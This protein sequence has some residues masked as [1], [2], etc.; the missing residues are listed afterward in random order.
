M[1][2]RRDKNK[3]SF[4]SRLWVF[5]AVI[6]LFSVSFSYM[7]SMYWLFDLF[8]H[9]VVQYVLIAALLTI[10]LLFAKRKM[11]AL[12][13]L[14][15]C[16]SQAYK[17]VP[18]FDINEEVTEDYDEVKVLQYNVNRNNVN[19]D[20]MTRWIVSKTEDVDIVVL[21]EVNERWQDAI[22]RIKWAYPYHISKD[23]RGGRNMAVFSRLYV[24]EIEIK[25]LKDESP[26]IVLRGE[27]TGYE[28]P[29]VLYGTHPPPPIFPSFAQTNQDVLESIGEH[30]VKEKIDHRLVVGDFNSTRFSPHFR[31]MAESSNMK[32]GDI[33]LGIGAYKPSW[34]SFLPNLMGITIDN[35]LVS[36]NIVVQKRE[37][38]PAMGSDHYPVITT[39]K[40][41]VPKENNG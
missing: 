23:M 35:I 20:E 12:I 14:V 4:I 18:Y 7:A 15:I 41:V 2:R 26:V 11:W 28:V 30:V 10:L 16:A 1:R 34:P 21:L 24:D 27:T 25:Y 6:L 31:K 36:N 38:G 13:T 33:G 22:R 32:E 5:L 29:F 3:K 40:F 17:V 8:S 39:L 19:V 37:R 9:F